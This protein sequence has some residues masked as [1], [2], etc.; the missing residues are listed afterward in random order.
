MPGGEGTLNSPWNA[1]ETEF[2]FT[3]RA[4]WLVTGDWTTLDDLT[5]FKSDEGTAAIGAAAH[6][7]RD[8]F[9]TGDP[10]VPGSFN[11]DEVDFLGL[12]ADAQVEFGGASHFGEVIYRNLDSDAGGSLDQFGAVVQGGV[13]L[14]EGWE[15]FA[16]Y[17][18]GDLDREGMDDLSIITAGLNRCYVRHALKWTT[19]IGYSFIELAAEW[20]SSG[21]GW[22]A[23]APGEDGQVLI[24][25]QF[26]LM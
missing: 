24:R 2:A 16:R 15:G 26:Q 25:S 20:A 1:E 10:A 14:A 23:D 21:V 7:Q 11:N 4:V 5:S 8:G 17:E 9:D 19:D 6:D 18:W 13:F 22:R 3:G 12:A